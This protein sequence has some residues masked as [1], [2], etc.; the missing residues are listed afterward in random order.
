MHPKSSATP[1]LGAPCSTPTPAALPKLVRLDNGLGV[2]HHELPTPV[3]NVDV[4]LAAGST[5]EPPGGAGMAHFLEHLIFKGT[6]RLAPG[7]FDKLVEDSG[8]LTNAGTSYDYV[9]YYICTLAEQ[10]PELLPALAELLFQAA[11][12]A[13]EFERERQV[14]LEEILQYEDDPDGVGAAALW[15][16]VYGE[17]HPYGRPILGDPDQ[18]LAQSPESLRRFHRQ[19]YRP[20]QMTLVIAGGI[21]RDRA[22]A[23]ARQH[24]QPA[25]PGPAT[26]AQPQLTPAPLPA[27]P[28][29]VRARALCG[30]PSP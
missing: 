3:V 8:G 19:H 15:A 6:Q 22:I 28:P 30:A 12:P 29:A 25:L 24:F 1:V 23:L 21:D 27:V 10:L 20:E 5:V 14:V 16:A 9:H 17:Q 26:A 2:L 18:L 13:G 4:W 7:D 11:I